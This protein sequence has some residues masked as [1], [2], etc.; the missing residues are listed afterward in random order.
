MYDIIDNIFLLHKTVGQF[1]KEETRIDEDANVL[2]L[3][4]FDPIS[5]MQDTIS[6]SNWNYDSCFFILNSASEDLESRYILDGL[7]LDDH[8]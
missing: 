1:F 6:H 5:V 7:Q 8:S 3:Q 4:G 2:T